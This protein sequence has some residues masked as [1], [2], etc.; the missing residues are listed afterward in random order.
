MAFAARKKNNTGGNQ[1]MSIRKILLTNLRI[2]GKCSRAPSYAHIQVIW[3]YF[4]S[5]VRVEHR[6]A[7]S[8][9]LY[10]P[11]Q[12]NICGFATLNHDEGVCAGTSSSVV[13]LRLSIG[14]AFRV[15]FGV[16]RRGLPMLRNWLHRIL[17]PGHLCFQV[18]QRPSL[19]YLA[20]TRGTRTDPTTQ[21]F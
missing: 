15:G 6:G 11:E 5:C 17:P 9:H 19:S 3:A 7:P 4:A 2:F 13:A 8:S 10:I 14:Q 20:P 12:V 21:L 18:A 1:G 16:A